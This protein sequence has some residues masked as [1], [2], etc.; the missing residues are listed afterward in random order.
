[1][2]SDALFWLMLT[3]LSCAIMSFY[4]MLEMACVSFNKVRLEYYVAQGHTRAIWLERLLKNPSKLFGTTLIG[5]NVALMM[6]S[7]CARQFYHA[8]GLSPSWAPLTQIPFVVI[9]GELAPMFAA[10][11]YAE[12]VTMLGISIVNASAKLMTPFLWIIDGIS[13]ITDWCLGGH[14]EKNVD[15]FLSRDEL[16]K[17]L[18]EQDEETQVLGESEE[19]NAVLS[20]IFTLKNKT[21]E[22]VMEPLYL[23]RTMPSNG[24]IGHMNQL[25]KKGQQSF[26]PIYHGQATNVVAIAHPRDLVRL[27]DTR[28]VR[29][30][31]RPPWFL[32]AD[33]PLFEILK[34]FRHNNQTVAVVLNRKGVC[35][36]ILTLD[37]VVTELFGRGG[38]DIK[39]PAVSP[40]DTTQV[41]E[42][43]LPGDLRVEEFNVTFEASLPLE[44]GETLSQLMAQ[45]L[46]HPPNVGEVAYF[47][48]YILTA[49]ETNLMGAKTITVRTKR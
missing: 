13:K 48:P 19:V 8:A 43:T 36:G 2:T 44:N 9:I 7:E 23:I 10:R 33:T 22:Q 14:S 15:S 27:P 46:G 39:E 24:T 16:K 18:E 26:L 5:V 20:N 37:D 40:A 34:Q 17:L 38:L 3:L 25:L 30:V 49:K 1:M 32:T 12:H 42:K 47:D 28:R 6:S 4:S 29:E 31:A 41:V 35:I 21:A 45:S 11:H